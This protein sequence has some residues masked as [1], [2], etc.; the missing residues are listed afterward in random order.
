MIVMASLT[1]ALF[2]P[3]GLANLFS[4]TGVW[5]G[6]IDVAFYLVKVFAVIFVAVIT[7]RVGFARLKISQ[8][9]RLFW[10]PV[11][12]VS[13]LGMLLLTLDRFV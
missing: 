4:V 12:G 8:V 10:L 6:L 11:T 2:F 5:G 13:L 7:V 9:T 1:V 3:Y